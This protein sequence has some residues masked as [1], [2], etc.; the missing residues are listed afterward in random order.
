MATVTVAFGGLTIKSNETVPK[1][2]TEAQTT[3]KIRNRDTGRTAGSDNKP[4]IFKASAPFASCIF[5]INNDQIDRAK[6][7]NTVIPMHNLLE[8]C[9]SYSKMLGRLWQHKKTNQ[10]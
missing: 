2:E 5:E 1:N 4:L 9:K 3:A 7:L 10:T 6:D 8:S